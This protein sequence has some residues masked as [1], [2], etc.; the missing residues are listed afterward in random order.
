[1]AVFKGSRETVLYL[2]KNGADALIRGMNGSSVLHICA[3]RNFVQ[4]AKDILE[5][6]ENNKALLFA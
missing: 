2:L 6:E 4:I 3:E 5:Y 1:M